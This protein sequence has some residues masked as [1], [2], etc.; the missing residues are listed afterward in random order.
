MKPLYP[1]I[2]S[3]AHTA[4]AATLLAFATLTPAQQSYRQAAT[5]NAPAI[6]AHEAAQRLSRAQLARSSGAAPLAGEQLG[7]GTE[8]TVSYRYWKRQERLRL[9]V[10]LAQRRANETR[11]PR[12][13]A[14]R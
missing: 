4:C 12:L 7:S 2:R 8:S 3:I 13:V 9:A 6:D 5:K 1:L 11:A 10:E 14:R